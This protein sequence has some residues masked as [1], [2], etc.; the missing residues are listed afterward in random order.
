MYTRNNEE[1]NIYANGGMAGKGAAG[2]IN[3]EH[4]GAGISEN[5]ALDERSSRYIMATL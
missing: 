3:R 5:S 1:S 2:V 4:N